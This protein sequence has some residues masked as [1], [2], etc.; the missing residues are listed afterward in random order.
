MREYIVRMFKHT[1]IMMAVKKLDEM[2]HAIKYQ[3][4]VEDNE[5]KQ[6]IYRI[7]HQVVLNILRDL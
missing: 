3:I 5:N 6:R 7:I 2:E 4:Q 1:L